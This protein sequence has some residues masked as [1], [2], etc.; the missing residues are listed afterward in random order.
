MSLIE[1]KELSRVFVRGDEEIR[2]LDDVSLTIEKGEFLAVVGPSGSGKSTLMYI[3]GLLDQ[4][5]SGSYILDGRVVS[6]LRD[7]ERAQLRNQKIGFVF[8]SFH[9]LPRATALRNVA[10]PLVYSAAYTAG[11]SETKAVSH[12]RDALTKVGLESRMTHLPNE[13]SGGQRQRVA[14]ARALVNSPAIILADEP[15]GNLDSKNG[16]EILHLFSTLNEQGVTV[17]LVTHD[18]E[19]ASNAHRVV[20]FKDGRIVGDVHATR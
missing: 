12:A 11:Y 3:L 9:L 1:V 5:T 7:D 13:L 2:A 14:I 6:D 10:M 19:V 8:Q 16:R 17:M 20:T 4:P 15:T 18:M